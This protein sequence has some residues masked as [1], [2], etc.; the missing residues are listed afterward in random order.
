MKSLQ[1]GHFT[2][3]KKNPDLSCFVG[4]TTERERERK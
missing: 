3:G 4:D 1:V 2:W